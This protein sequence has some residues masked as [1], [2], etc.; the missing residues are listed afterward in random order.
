MLDQKSDETF[1][2]AERRAMNAKWRL[3]GVVAIFVNEIEPARLR[4]VVL[5]GRDGKLA[6]DRAP[7]LHVDLRA[8]ERGFVW[9][10]DD[11]DSGILEH[12]SRLLFCLLPQFWLIDM[13]F[14]ELAGIVGRGTHQM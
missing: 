7:G 13:L 9:H 2:R 4:E 8:V 11:I 14:P 3:L 5:V 6:A 10:L 1:V 12:A